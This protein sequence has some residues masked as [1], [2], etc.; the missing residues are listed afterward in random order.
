MKLCIHRISNQGRIQFYILKHYFKN[1][2]KANTLIQN[3]S[4]KKFCCCSCSCG[5]MFSSL[6]KCTYLKVC[7]FGC[8]WCCSCGSYC[9]CCNGSVYSTLLTIQLQI[10]CCFCCS[11]CWCYCCCS[12]CC[13]CCTLSSS[14]KCHLLKN[15]SLKLQ[16]WW[17]E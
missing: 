12:S 6:F 2:N 13:C 10:C 4:N 15:V 3:N 1:E 17:T 16:K 7:C 14:F 11:C 8:C 9:C 5:N